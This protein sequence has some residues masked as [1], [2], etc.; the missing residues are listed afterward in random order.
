MRALAASLLVLVA[1]NR[2][3]SQPSA[4][5]EPSGATTKTATSAAADEAAAAKG[6]IRIVPATQDEAVLSLV[7]TERLK[8]KAEGRVLVVYV[9]ATW[10]EPCKRLKAEIEAGRLDDRLGRTTL[11]AFDADADLDRLSSAG[12]AF[13]FVPYVALPGPDGRPADTEEATGSG[14]GAWRALLGKLDAWQGT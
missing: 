2:P 4:A 7:R 5:A 3:S 14:G 1:C 11:L 13:K 12:Y 8:A 10:C 6:K 9:S